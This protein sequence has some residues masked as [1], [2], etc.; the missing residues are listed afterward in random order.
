MT[1]IPLSQK[2]IN[3]FYR[4]GMRFG[5]TS[6]YAW[7]NMHGRFATIIRLSQ[8]RWKVHYMS[9]DYIFYNQSEMIEWIDDQRKYGDD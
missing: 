9:H 8:N 7:F 4:S 1:F 2:L 6:Y 3:Y 5:F